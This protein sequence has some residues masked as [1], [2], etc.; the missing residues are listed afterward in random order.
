MVRRFRVITMIINDFHIF[1]I[2]GI[3]MHFHSIF[4][5]L[6]KGSFMLSGVGDYDKPSL[7]YLKFAVH[8]FTLLYMILQ[9]IFHPD[10]FIH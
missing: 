4:L 10:I 2:F 5:W 6:I 8:D 1:G 7:S 3:R 9:I